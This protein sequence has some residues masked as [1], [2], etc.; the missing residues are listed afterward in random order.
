MRC[1]SHSSLAHLL[2]FLV[3]TRIAASI[4]FVENRRCSHDD[5]LRHGWSDGPVE[6]VPRLP[7]PETTLAVGGLSVLHGQS[8]K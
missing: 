3:E 1:Q 7:V 6:I 4:A 2:D 5:R 8:R